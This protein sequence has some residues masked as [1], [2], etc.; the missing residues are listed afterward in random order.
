MYTK[1]KQEWVF[2]CDVHDKHIRYSTANT[3][4]KFTR[5][6][7]I[8]LIRVNNYSAGTMVTYKWLCGKNYSTGTDVTYKWCCVYYI[9][10]VVYSFEMQ[11]SSQAY[12]YTITQCRSGYENI[13]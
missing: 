12:M 1:S 9:V 4:V 3:L 2:T 5:M 10:R 13:S 7:P 11:C 6:N 8:E